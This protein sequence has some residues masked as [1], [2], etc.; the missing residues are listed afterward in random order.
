M[1]VAYYTLDDAEAERK[2]EEER[3]KREEDNKKYAE[4]SKKRAAERAEVAKN[5][6]AT[7]TQ[8]LAQKSNPNAKNAPSTDQISLWG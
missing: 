1:A 5:N 8:P 7:D 4:E 2:K 6:Q 3:K